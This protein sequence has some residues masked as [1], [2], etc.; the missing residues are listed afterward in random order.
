[1]KSPILVAA[2]LALAAVPAARAADAPAPAALAEPASGEPRWADLFARLPVAD[3][4][5][6]V[7]GR[8]SSLSVAGFLSR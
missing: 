4:R 7:Q 3:A 1:M 6:V 2:V 5:L 8:R